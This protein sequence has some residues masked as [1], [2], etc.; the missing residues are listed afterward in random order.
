MPSVVRRFAFAL[1][2]VVVGTAWGDHSPQDA[3][4]PAQTLPTA[5]DLRPQFTAW[6]LV[7]H[8][9][10]RRNTCSVFT[11]AAALE[12]AASKQ[13]GQGRPLSVEYLNWAANQ[14]I[15]NQTHDRGQ[16]F[17]HLLAGFERYGACPEAD[18]PYHHR[19]DP[20]VAPTPEVE[21][22][23]RELAAAGLVVHWI[24][25]LTHEQ[26]LSDGQF[27]E[28]RAVLAH[29]WPVAAG[30]NHSRLLVGYRDDEGQPGGGEFVTKDSGEGG[31][32]QVT[33]EF[34]KTRVGD[35]FWVEAPARPAAPPA[36]S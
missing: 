4:P 20:A 6:G 2:W 7:P 5:V 3:A 8:S 10:G 28:V 35:A 22:K 1:P 36:G 17:H 11:T 29:G 16:F 25:P 18:L 23:A 14:V 15:G 19:F 27:H 32:G 34:V 31:W 24:R 26:G 13:A 30:S 9:Q 33:Y 12:F 21:A